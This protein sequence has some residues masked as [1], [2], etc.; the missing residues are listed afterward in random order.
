M[1]GF[2]LIETI[3]VVAIVLILISFAIFGYRFFRQETDLN[4]AAEEI[5]NILRVAQNKTLASE[6]GSKY[7][8]YFD[9]SSNAHTLFKGDEFSTRDPLFDEVHNIPSF[10][11]IFDIDLEGEAL[12]VVFNRI[13]GDTSQFGTISLRLQQDHTKTKIVYIDNTGS[14]SLVSPTSPS[15]D[16]R[17]KDSR[18][19]HFTY[20]QDVTG[21]VTLHLV[22][23]DYPADNFDIDFQTYLNLI[24]N[25]FSWEGTVPVG[26]LGSKTDQILKIHTHVIN[27]SSA[28]FSVTRDRRYN[29]RALEIW[30]DSENLL[31]YAADGTTTKGSSIHVSEEQWQ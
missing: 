30:L 5:L 15:D 27:V 13:S 18:H 26:P 11:E 12:E 16:D 8:V 2:T 31:N 14:S 6:A 29:D 4:N 22:F 20:S 10:V 23:P 1:K 17:V 7:G 25:E 24:L 3:V 19:V 21:A 28:D 9:Q